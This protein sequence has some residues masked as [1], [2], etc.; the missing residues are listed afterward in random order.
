MERGKKGKCSGKQIDK[1]MALGEWA[2]QSKLETGKRCRK[3]G[4]KFI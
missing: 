2:E 1:H 4:K 3:Y